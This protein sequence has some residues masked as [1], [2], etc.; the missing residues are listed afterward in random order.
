MTHYDFQK[1]ACRYLAVA[2]LIKMNGDLPPYV[3]DDP[4]TESE[5][6]VARFAHNRKLD[7][8]LLVEM[9]YVAHARKNSW[10]LS[11]NRGEKL[12]DTAQDHFEERIHGIADKM[13][14]KVDTNTGLWVYITVPGEPECPIPPFMMG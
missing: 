1:M 11:H 12:S 5:A 6:N 14:V 3:F 4:V 8:A 9:I 10:E 13:G 2:S 7:P